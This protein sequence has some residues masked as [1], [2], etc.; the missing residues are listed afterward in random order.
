MTKPVLA[1]T[2]GDPAGTG[3]EIIARAF[4]EKHVNEDAGLL[5]VG[6]ARTLEKAAEIVGLSV[7]R[8][9]ID[10]VDEADFS[11][12]TL[13]GLDLKNVDHTRLD[14]GQIQAMAGQAA[15]EYIDVA[16]K[17]AMEKKVDGVVTSAIH[18]ESLHLAGHKYAGH[19]EIFAEKT[20]SGR[21]T[22]MLAAGDFRVTHVSTHCSLREAIERCKTPRILDVI[23]LTNT[24]LQRIGIEESR[25]IVE[26]LHGDSAS[27]RRSKSR[28]DQCN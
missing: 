23:R 10:A 4:G 1:I 8:Q 2:M 12:D 17:L 3:A 5:C 27:Y 9:V 26:G 14:P 20:G 6:D 18:K 7:T 19:T 11:P 15:F 13:N 28:R 16:I 21:V 22:M 25:G 24:S